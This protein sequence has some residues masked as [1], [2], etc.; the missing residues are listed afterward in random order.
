MCT[1]YQYISFEI[2]V[3]VILLLYLLFTTDKFQKSESTVT[4][5]VLVKLGI[6]FVNETDCCL[7]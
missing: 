6:V 4:C 7:L 5:R 3:R 1:G 2:Y